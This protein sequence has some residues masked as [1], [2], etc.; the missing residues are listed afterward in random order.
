MQ[1]ADYN[2]VKRLLTVINFE[3]PASADVG[4]E[5]ITQCLEL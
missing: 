5:F 4:G 3:R 1:D 2:P